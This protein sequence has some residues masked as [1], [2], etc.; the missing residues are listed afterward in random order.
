VL[1]ALRVLVAQLK[2]YMGRFLGALAALGVGSSINLVFPEVVR[3]A[4]DEATFPGARENVGLIAGALGLLFVVQAAA[5]YLRALLFGSIGQRVFSDVRERLFRSIMARD[6]LF[7]DSTRS[8][9]LASR[10]N[11]DAALVQDAVSIRL[12]VILRYGLQ[13]VLG[14]ALMAWMSWRMT[15]AIVA[16]VVCMVAVSSVFVRSLRAASRAY[17]SALAALTSYAAECFAGSK[18]VQALGAQESAR[19]S[20]RSMNWRVLQSGERRVR[21]SASFSSGAGLLL[22][23]LLLVVLWYGIHLVG[24]AELPLSSLAAFAL[25]GAIVAVS[26]SFLV[27]AYAELMQSIGGLERVFELMDSSTPLAAPSMREPGRIEGI[28]VEVRDVFFSYPSRPSQPVLDGLTFSVKAGQMTGLVGP[29]GS[30]K[31][32][33]AQLLLKFYAPTRGHITLNG[34]DL[35]DINEDAVR[36]SIAWVPQDPCLFGFTVFENL[37]FG[38]EKLLR[39]EAERLVQSWKFM[40]FAAALPDGIDTQLGE[41]GTQLSGGQR[42]RLAIARAILRKPSLL[43]LDEATS[44]LDSETEAQVLD[45]I[46]LAIPEATLLVIS[47]RLSTVRGAVSIV[48]INEGRV[49]EQGTHED[50]K[51]RRGLYQEYAMRQALG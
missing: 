29:S 37:I 15:A 48:V 20:F 27:G 40:D 5:F 13:V 33:L 26:F 42:Q 8:G 9:D 3:R 14:T 16:S 49:F 4:L 2:P 17:Q 28:T 1:S 30:G 11:S 36:E 12:S 24:R 31:S 32:S 47:H 41:Q 39:Q 44:G 21:V 7:F 22:N 19:Q 45:A 23:L 51:S 18:I 46:R 10:I 25:Y 38:N 50:L 6:A 34:I 43:I 35:A